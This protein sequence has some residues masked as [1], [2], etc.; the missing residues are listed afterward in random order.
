MLFRSGQ[1]ARAASKLRES[2]KAAG[3]DVFDQTRL[4]PGE[5]WNETVQRMIAQSDGVIGL[6]GTDDV[7]PFVMNELGV[8]AQSSKPSVV[9]VSKGSAAHAL[10]PEIPRL[11][12]DS[13]KP[14]V[15]GIVE[16]LKKQVRT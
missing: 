12:F 8:A 1:D 14:N 9:L 13:N 11:Q 6:V 16:F 15:S 10:P 7:S 5:P 4:K 3:I 2:L